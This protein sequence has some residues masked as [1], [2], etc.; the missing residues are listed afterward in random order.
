MSAHS[1]PGTMPGTEAMQGVWNT[2]SISLGVSDQLIYP[3]PGLAHA[4]DQFALE[5]GTGTMKDTFLLSFLS[6]SFFF[7]SFFLFFKK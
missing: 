6:P 2:V 4:P 5:W 3:V 7:L 1:V